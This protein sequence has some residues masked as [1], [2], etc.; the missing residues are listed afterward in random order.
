MGP[1]RGRPARLRLPWLLFGAAW[2][3]SGLPGEPAQDPPAA[4]RHV[5]LVSVDGLRPSA[6]LPAPGSPALMPVVAALRARGSWAEAVEGQYPSL[7]YP[8]HTSIVT[9]VRPARHGIMHNTKFGPDGPSQ[10]WYFESA[11][12][13]VPALWDWARTAGLRVGAVSWPV[14]VGAPI[15]YL[16]PETHQSPPGTTWLDLVREQSTP[17]LID[18]VVERLG[19]FGPRDNLDYVQRDRFAAAAAAQIIERDRPHLLLV[20]LVETDGAQHAY[21]PD[22]SQARAAFARVDERIGEI[23]AAVERAGL[24]ERTAWIVTGDHGFYR[25]HSAFQPNAALGQAGL[26]ETNASGR[27]T[28]WRAVAHRAT[29]RLRDPSDAALAHRVETLFRNLADGPYRGLFSVVGGDEI[30]RLGGDPDALLMIEPI[31]GY[32]VTAGTEGGFL[33]ASARRGDH[34]YLPAMPSMRTGLVLAGAGIARGVVVPMARQIDVAP[35]A[36]RLLGLRHADVDGIALEG[37]LERA[38]ARRPTNGDR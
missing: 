13:R 2:L 8:S 32:T 15:D 9:G 21:G 38:A 31:D 30:R 27:V 23:V 35:T 33:V 7:T 12:I 14:T 3:L 28:S 37:V 17:G 4:A 36:A 6:Y 26:L 5:V 19:G 22:S 25:V 16:F 1:P 34:G 29:I 18:A 10:D 24:A 11:A 20:H